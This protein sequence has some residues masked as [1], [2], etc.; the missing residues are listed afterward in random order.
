MTTEQE[1][2]IGEKSFDMDNFT[3]HTYKSVSIWYD[4]YPSC[5][6]DINDS[7]LNMTIPNQG[8]FSLEQLNVAITC[9]AS[10][11]EKLVDRELARQILDCYS[12]FR[13]SNEGQELNIRNRGGRH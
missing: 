11:L 3:T 4:P 13:I 12:R 8:R 9:L 1:L 6:I 5:K 2:M 7:K 10:I